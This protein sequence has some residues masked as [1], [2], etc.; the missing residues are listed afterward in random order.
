MKNDNSRV[1]VPSL[2]VPS[3][4]L[5]TGSRGGT[6]LDEAADRIPTQGSVVMP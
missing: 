6:P 3:S 2:D 5:M 1:P 4:A